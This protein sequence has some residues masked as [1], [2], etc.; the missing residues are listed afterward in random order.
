MKPQLQRALTIP[1]LPGLCLIFP[2]CCGV[3]AAA[4]AGGH[5]TGMVPLPPRKPGKIAVEKYTGTISGK[6]A[7]APSPVAGVWLVGTDTRAE[8]SPPSS[9]LPQSGY[10]FTHSLIIVPVGAKVE[11]PNMDNDYHNVASLSPAKTFDI[12]RYKKDERPVPFRIFD[13]EGFIS[14]RCE[15]HDHMNAAILVVNS[16]WRTLTDPSGKFT[17]RDVPPGPYT[18]HA[19]IDKNTRWSAPIIISAGKTTSASFQSSAKLP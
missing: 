12:G 3:L 18:L 5:V 1:M 13:K 16:R 14:L 11:F 6:V 17:I 7:A 19:Q 10:Q 8:H 4:P 15:I 2:L 9:S